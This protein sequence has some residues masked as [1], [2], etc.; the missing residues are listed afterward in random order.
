[1]DAALGSLN[2][3]MQDAA[4]LKRV[5]RYILVTAGN[6]WVAAEQGITMMPMIINSI[7]AI[8]TMMRI[9]GEKFM[10]RLFRPQ[11]RMTYSMFIMPPLYFLQEYDV[12][13]ESAQTMNQQSYTGR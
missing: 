4:L 3:A 5:I 9:T 1:M 8:G 2:H 11:M 6:D 7:H 10:L 12:G 13:A